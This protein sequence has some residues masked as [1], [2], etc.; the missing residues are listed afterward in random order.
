MKKEIYI[1]QIKVIMRV[2]FLDGLTKKMNIVSIKNMMVLIENFGQMK[3]MVLVG[4]V[5]IGVQQMN[6]VIIRRIK[7]DTMEKIIGLNRGD[8]VMLDVEIFYVKKMII[9]LINK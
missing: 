1:I 3:Q 5:K 6:G 8:R 9:L 4:G 2:N 7:R